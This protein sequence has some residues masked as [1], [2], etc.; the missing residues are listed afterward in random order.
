VVRLQVSLCDKRLYVTLRDRQPQDD[1][2]ADV[3]LRSRKVNVA[4]LQK[5][6]RRIDPNIDERKRRTEVD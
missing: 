1:L 5:R 3:F 6:E 4:K 2:P